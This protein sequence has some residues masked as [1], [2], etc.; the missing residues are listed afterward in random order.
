MTTAEIIRLRKAGFTCGKIAA[1]AGVSRSTIWRRCKKWGVYPEIQV[2]HERQLRGRKLDGREE[3]VRHLYWDE[4]LSLRECAERLGVSGQTLL[5]F[6]YA[7]EIPR[8]DRV[9]A[10]GMKFHGDNPPRRSPN[11]RS[12]TS[13]TARQA[14]EK[15][16]RER[17]RRED[18]NRRYR[19]RRAARSAV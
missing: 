5:M 6:M 12:F 1:D 3:E 2:I 15:Y 17:R 9:L 11:A 10:T 4:K 16:W 18:K 8:R 7:R 13:E 14:V 19:E